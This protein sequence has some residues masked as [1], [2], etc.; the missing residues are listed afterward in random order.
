MGWCAGELTWENY[1]PFILFFLVAH[2]NR[3]TRPSRRIPTL[4]SDMS[5]DSMTAVRGAQTHGA[6]PK[7]NG[8]AARSPAEPCAHFAHPCAGDAPDDTPVSATS[9]LTQTWAHF[10][11]TFVLIFPIYALGYFEFSFSWLLIGLVIFFWWRRNTGGKHSR[12][13]R[14]LAFFE[15]EERSVKQGLTT[16]DLPPWVSW[17]VWMK[18]CLLQPVSPVVNNMLEFPGQTISW[19]EH[20]LGC[21]AV[22]EQLSDPPTPPPPPSTDTTPSPSLNTAGYN[23][24]PDT[25]LERKHS[26]RVLL[27]LGSSLL[28]VL[29]W[30]TVLCI[31]LKVSYEQFN[32]TWYNIYIIVSAY[33]TNRSNLSN[34]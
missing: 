27:I 7:E 4:K 18:E 12:L 32:H 5:R 14:A 21:K 29:L 6:S 3:V 1:L 25:T 24:K 2:G 8:H 33:E 13:S 17:A 34:L 22:M 19:Q 30:A 16:S 26:H 10:A 11:K 15:Q 31:L 9:E 28:T 20:E 23:S